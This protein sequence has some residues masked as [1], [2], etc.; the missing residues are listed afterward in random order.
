MTV[1]SKAFVALGRAQSTA[2][3]ARGLPIIEIPHPFG[4][5]TR[6]EI[7]SIAHSCADQI[8]A[9]LSEHPVP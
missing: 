6:Q 2:M 1:C 5:R 7:V 9:Y 3:G 8:Q 4:S